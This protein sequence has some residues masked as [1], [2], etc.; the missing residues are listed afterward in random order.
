MNDEGLNPPTKRQRLSNVAG[1]M[2]RYWMLTI[3]HHEFTPFLPAGVS[4]IKGQLELG[5]GT[6]DGGLPG[7]R[8]TNGSGSGGRYLHWQIVV[9]LP[10]N[11]RLSAIRKIFGPFHAELTRSDAALEYV[12]KD[13]TRV[14]GTQ[15]ELGQLA[16]KRNSPRDWEA[17]L[18]HA[19]AG[20]IGLIDAA[21][22]ICHY[23]SLKAIAADNLVPIGIERKIDVF[24]GPTGTG[25]SRRAWAEA[26]ITA[27]P[28]DP[29]SKFWD[30]Y[31]G[32]EHVVIDE[33]RG[34]I[35]IGHMLR[36]LDRYPVI[37]EIK[38]SSVCLQATRIWITS[39]LDPKLWYP[40]LDEA[41][42]AALLR[43]CDVTRFLPGLQAPP[44]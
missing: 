26:G 9:G 42:Q 8:T 2:G 3:P 6:D 20:N 43:R 34:G 41:T 10:S 22:Q 28:K 44:S 31:R 16:F 37:V 29:R 12:W 11:A 35:D 25:K 30:G 14:D 5:N 4:Y 23:R 17:N 21:T 33:F 13:D 27:Y 7:V 1:K 19:Q 18:A 36:W 39:N 32:Q 40:E 24:H 38:G 15:F